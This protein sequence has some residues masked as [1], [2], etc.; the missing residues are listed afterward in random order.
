MLLAP[1]TL[2]LRYA[3]DEDAP[4]L[5]MLRTAAL[6]ELDLLGAA[7]APV[8]RK[9]ARREIAA[10]LRDERMIAWVLVAGDRVAGCACAIFW[11]RL[12]YAGSSCHA[13]ISGVYVAPEFR[14]R[15]IAR[16]LVGEAIASARVRA[17][18]RVFI[19]PAPRTREFYRS[20][21]FDDAGW[22]RS[23]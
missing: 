12:P 16:E 3:V 7:E 19:A 11:D 17:V 9:R 2:C 13:E 14:R 18:R 21:G 20:F 4:A 6:L 23:P 8:F 22:L 15:G 10:M 5:A 1:Q